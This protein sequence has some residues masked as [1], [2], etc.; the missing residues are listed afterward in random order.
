MRRL[1][2]AAVEPL[3]TSQ[4]VVAVS[5]KVLTPLGPGAFR[6]YVAVMLSML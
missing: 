4:S 1:A 2:P 6:R 5:W 3:Q